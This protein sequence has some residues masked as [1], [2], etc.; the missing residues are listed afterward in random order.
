LTDEWYL[1]KIKSSHHIHIATGGGAHEDPEAN[2]R[3]CQILWNKGIWHDLDIWGADINHDW[4]TWRAMLPY[5]L[6]TKF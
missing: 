3:F 5:I 4:P 6:E 2:R 1:N